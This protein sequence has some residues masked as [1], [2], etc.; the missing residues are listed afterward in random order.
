[1]RRFLAISI[2]VFLIFGIV[3]GATVFI[4]QRM[5]ERGQVAQQSQEQFGQLKPAEPGSPQIVESTD[6]DKDGLPNTEEQRWGSD[7]TNPDTDGDGYLDGEEI[8]ARHNPTI[9]APN[10]L[11]PAQLAPPQPAPAVV[12]EPLKNVDQYFAEGLDLTLGTKD[13]TEEYRQL[14][15]AEERTNE[16]L[17]TYARQQPIITQLPSIADKPIKRVTDDSPAALQRYLAVAGNLTSFYP[18]QVFAEALVDLYQNNDPS[19]IRGV[20]LVVRLH[21]QDLLNAEVPPSAEPLH[22]LSIGYMDLLLAT[23]EQM[24]RYPDDPV[25]STVAMRQLEEIDRKYFSLIAGEVRRLQ[26]LQ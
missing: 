2:V 11:L 10:D 7:P 1:M 21:Q 23:Y 13:F 18:Q 22:K 12:G 26:E 15:P 19:A 25:R 20:A 9:P 14:Y 17:I 5:R 24:A 8:N 4:V 16:T 6:D 3:G